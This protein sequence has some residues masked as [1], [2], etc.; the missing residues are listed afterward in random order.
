MAERKFFK[1][2]IYWLQ[3]NNKKTKHKQ[4]NFSIITTKIIFE[5]FQPSLLK[6][7]K[8]KREQMNM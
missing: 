5:F 1:R 2:L 3:K 7:Q 8:K 4:K 6:R